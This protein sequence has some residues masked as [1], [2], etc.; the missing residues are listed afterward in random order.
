MIV[1]LCSKCGG[2]VY[3]VEFRRAR[4]VVERGMK[5]A[6]CGNYDVIGA[7]SRPWELKPRPR[8]VAPFWWDDI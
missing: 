1:M 2:P 8:E 6:R 4:G 5:C 7:Y 3:P